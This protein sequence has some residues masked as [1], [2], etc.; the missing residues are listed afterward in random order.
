MLSDLSCKDLGAFMD[1][2]LNDGDARRFL[3][4]LDTCNACRKHFGD[5]LEVD[6]RLSYIAEEE[7]LR[8]LIRTPASHALGAPAQRS[9][10]L[11][12]PWFF[13]KVC[14]DCGEKLA[15]DAPYIREAADPQFPICLSCAEKLWGRR[16]KVRYLQG[17]H[18]WDLNLSW[19]RIVVGYPAPS[20]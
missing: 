14:G 2:E 3:D 1:Y 5:A 19:H 18:D 9:W 6:A 17:A 11:W 13:Y 8:T 10:I 12:I 4:H 16:L 7:N 20:A 15:G